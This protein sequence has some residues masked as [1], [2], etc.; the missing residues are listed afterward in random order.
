[1]ASFVRKAGWTGKDM[2]INM[3]ANLLPNGLTNLAE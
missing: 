2:G 1:M 3:D